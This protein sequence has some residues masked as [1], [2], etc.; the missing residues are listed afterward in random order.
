MRSRSRNFDGIVI[1][2]RQ[3]VEYGSGHVPNAI[4]IGL[5][6]QFATWAGTMIP[7]GTP[8]A[9]AA[10]TQE[11]VDE[12]FTRLAR[13]GHETVRGYVMMSDFADER[14]VVEQVPVAEV[15]ALAET[16]KHLQFVDVR[17]PAEY[18]N[19][20]A[21][22]T[23][24]IP[25]D[26]LSREIDQLDP[27][28]PTYVICQSGYRSSLGASILENAG[29]R[30]VYNVSGGTSAWTDADLPTEVEQTACQAAS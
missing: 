5:G 22:R 11:Q 26:R 4:N 18:A 8:I 20:H 25:L 28:V 12:A 1:D 24:S 30:K 2:V 7:I 10:D 15:A 17:R 29:F 13:V 27:T 23:V 14:K 6:G 21:V 19:G 9:I 3:N 16:E